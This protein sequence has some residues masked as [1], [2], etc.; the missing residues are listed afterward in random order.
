MAD[1]TQSKVNAHLTWAHERLCWESTAEVSERL[2]DD[3]EFNK[4]IEE[5][6]ESGIL[7][8]IMALHIEVHK[9]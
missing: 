9:Y 6:E 2:V 7:G 3:D 4:D 5:V 1:E 8:M